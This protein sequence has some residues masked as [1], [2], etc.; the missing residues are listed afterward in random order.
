[1]LVGLTEKIEGSTVPLT[2]LFENAGEVT[3]E[4]PVKGMAGQGSLDHGSHTLTN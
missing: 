3:L 2:L 1:M 4:V